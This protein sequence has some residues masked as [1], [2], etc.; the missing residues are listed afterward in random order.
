MGSLIVNQV[1]DW[2][3]DGTIDMEEFNGLMLNVQSN[4]HHKGLGM[5]D[6]TLND[7]SR[8]FAET[9]MDTNRASLSPSEVAKVLTKIW[10]YF[11]A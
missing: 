3:M 8:L 5:A 1:Y 6:S 2:N 11:S 7:V 4:L 9:Q 10:S